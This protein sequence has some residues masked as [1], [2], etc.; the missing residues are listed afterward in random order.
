VLSIAVR[1]RLWLLRSPLAVLA[2]L[3]AAS[4]GGGWAAAGAGASG[5]GQR[6][7]LVEQ[8]TATSKTFRDGRG[9]VTKELY[10]GP[11]HFREGGRWK[12]ID[13][14]LV[15]AAENERRQGYAWRM[16]SHRF[17]VLVKPR[18][19]EGFLRFDADGTPVAFSLAGANAAAGSTRGGEVTFAE[20]LDGV[21]LRY[22]MRPEGVK[23]ELILKHR[24]APST[25][26]FHLAMPRGVQLSAQ[27]VDGGGYAFRRRSGGQALFFLHAPF[28]TDAPD[29]RSRPGARTA[30][31]DRDRRDH[32]ALRVERAPGG[33][34]VE[35]AVDESWLRAEGR[36]FPVTVDPTITLQPTTRDGN[37]DVS[38]GACTVDEWDVIDIG[39]DDYGAWRGAFQFDLGQIPPGA[40]VSGAK[41][42]LFN[43]DMYC[44]YTTTED[45]GAR[46]H[47]L[48]VHRMTKAW[49]NNSTTSQLGWDSIAGA[50]TTVPA[51]VTGD[52]WIEFDV[53][54]MV[55]SWVSGATT[56]HGFLVKR[57]TE[58]LDVGG[59]EV[60]GRTWTW[61]DAT[62]RPRLEVTY[63]SDAVQF[64]APETLHGNGAA[65]RWERFDG[66]TGA[67]F[68][69]YEVHRSATASFTPSESTRLATIRDVGVTAFRDTTAAPSKTFTYRIVANGSPSVAQTVT[70][71]ADGQARKVLQ[72]DPRDGQS[73]LVDDIGGSTECGNYG[74]DEFVNVGNDG[75]RERSLLRFDLAGLPANAD[76][77]TATLSAYMS[78]TP[79]NAITIGAHRVTAAWTEGS[80]SWGE[81][82]YDGASWASRT[83]TD[84]WAAP[85][86]DYVSTAAATKSHAATDG[87]GWDAFDVTSIVRSWASGGA[88][89][90]GILLRA[91]DEAPGTNRATWI[92]Y[93]SDDYTVSP[94]LRPKLAVDYADPGAKVVGPTVAVAAPLDGERVR[95]TVN[96]DAAA[97]DDR[98]VE[99]VEFLVDGVVKATDTAAPYAYAWDT[100]TA[101]NGSHALTVRA[102][103]DAGNVRTS[104]AATVTVG[105]S[106]PPA[107]RVT[108]PSTRY[109]DVV[110]AD[111]P[112][113]YWRLGETSGTTAAD[114]SGNGRNGAYADSYLL[115]Q[116]GLLTGDTDRAVK[117]QNAKWDG[118]MTAAVGAN[119][120]TALTAEAW[121][122]YAPVVTTGGM[123]RVLA[124]YWGSSGG[125]LLAVAKSSAGQQIAQF[126]INKGGAVSNA[127]AVV[128]PGK[129]HLAGTYDG[130][131]MRLYVNGAQVAAT[132]LS[133]ALLNTTASIVAGQVVDTDTT[134]D[135]AAAFG[136]ALSAQQ[137]Q[138]HVDVGSGRAI[139]ITGAHTVHAT[140]T[141]DGTVDKVEFYVDGNRFGEDT[142]APYSATLD[143]LG[144]E[145]VYDGAH[146]LTT[147]AYDNHGQVTTSA[148]MS[149]TVANATGS[150]Y[151]ADVASTAVPQAVTYDPAAATQDKHGLDV[152]VTNRSQQ[153]WS[154][155]DVVVRPR[156]IS[157]DATAQIVPGAEVSL[158]AALAPG[159]AKTVRVLVE[160]P[161]LP[162]G[163]DKAQY[164]L[165]VDLYEKS[166]STSFADKG[167]KPLENPVIVN[168]ALLTALGFEKYYQ[169][170]GEELGAGMQQMLN[171]ANG[172]SLLRWTPFE[173]RGR[174]LM[175]VVDL[176]YN[177]LEK[178]SE[179]PIGN[180]FSLSISGLTRFG[181]PIDV[182]PNKADE[183]AGRSNRYVDITDGDG[184]THRFVGRQAADGSVYWEEPDGVH[185]HLRSL[186]DGDPKGKWAF[187]RPDRVTFFYDVEGFPTRVEDAN[188]NAIVYTHEDTP[189]GEDPGGPKKR[190]TRITDAGGRSFG[191]AY[192]SKDEAKK[193]QVRGNVK[194]ITDHSGSALDFDYYDDGNL[195]RLTQRG[196]TNADGTALADRSFVFTYT[197]SSGDAAAIPAAA[198]RVSPDPKTSN[199]STRLFSVRD[200]RGNETTFTYLGPG[201]GQDRWKLASRRDRRNV[202]TTFSYDTTS[203]V[204][205]LNAPLGRTTKYG[206]DVEGKVL[207]IVDPRNDT[208]RL[209]WTA[210]RH[211]RK[212]VEPTGRFTEFAYD[213]NG[214]LTD[215]WNQKREHTKLEYTYPAAIPG[216]VAGRWKAGRTV[217]HVS[218]LVKKTD[219]NGMATDAPGDHEWEFTHDDRGN[220]LKVVDPLDHFTER[221][222]NADG[223]VQWIKD[224][225][226]NQTTF[227]AYD[228][229]GQPSEV[230]DA[231]N[232]KTRFG[233]D[234]DGLLRWVQDPNHAGDSGAAGTER[235]FRTYFDYD[236]FH[237]MGRQSAPK[238]T[239]GDRGQL[240][241]SGGRF[242]PNDNLVEMIGPHKGADYTGTG[243]K[244]THDY[245][246]VD[247]KTL[248]TGP[249][250][251]VDPAGERTRW[252]YDDAN[253]V[254]RI[255]QP[256]GMMTP[257]VD[258]D[259]AT[260]YEY[261]ALDRVLR[262]IR[263]EYDGATLKSTQRIHRCYDGAGDL[264]WIVSARAGVDAVD[265]T[266][267]TPP[268]FATTYAYD[269]A[270][271]MLSQTDAGHGEA[272]VRHT[273]RRELDHNG[274]VRFEIDQRG[275]RS[276]RR[277]DQR[278]QLVEM[279]QPFDTASGKLLSTKYEYDFA[280]NRTKVTPPRG[281]STS[282]TYDKVNRLRRVDLPKKPD[283]DEQQYV[284]RAYDANGNLTATSLPVTTLDPGAGQ[285]DA[286]PA[287]HKTTV[288]HYDPGWVKTQDAPGRPRTRFDYTPEGWQ[289]S[290]QADIPNSKELTWE[291]YVDGA[292]RSQ[293]DRRGDR[294]TYEYDAHNNVTFVNDAS[295][296]HAEGET[297]VDIRVTRD[298]LDR[299]TVVKHQKKGTDR[300]IATRLTE[301]DLGNNLRERI[302][303]VEE[304]DTG[305]VLK[306]GRR[307]RFDYDDGE[308][309]TVQY[310]YG[311]KDGSEADKASDD[312]RITTKR[313]ETGW[314]QERVVAKWSGSDF[315][316]VKQR[317]T[318]DYSDNGKLE[319]MRTRNGQDEVLESHDVEYFDD[320][321]AYVNGHRVK[322][323]FVLRGPKEDAKC[324][325]LASPCVTKYTYDA[326]DKLVEEL[327]ERNG[328]TKKTT[329]DLDTQG[330]VDVE[331]RADGTTIDSDYTGQRLD[332]QT[333]TNGGAR[334]VKKYRYDRE[335]NLDCTYDG[336]DGSAGPTV[337]D[338]ADSSPSSKLLEKYDYDELNR[339]TR[340]RSWDP[341]T[342]ARDDDTTYVYDAL[343]RVIFQNEQHGASGSDQDRETTFSYL[344]TGDEVTQER[345][346]Y[347]R[348]PKADAPQ[349][350]TYSYDAFGNRVGM[351]DERGNRPAKEYSY[352]VDVHGS[353]SLLVD[354]AGKA[355]AQYGYTPY[356]ERD[357][358]LTKE[359]DP[360]KEADPTQQDKTGNEDDAVNP[361]RYAGKRFDSGSETLDMGAR[362]FGPEIGRFIQQ[363]AYDDALDDLDLSTDPLSAN[364]YA[365]A[366]GNPVSFVEADGHMLRTDGGG[367]ATRTARPR[368]RPTRST[369]RSYSFRT[370]ASS[371]GYDFDRGAVERAILYGGAQSRWK[372]F[373]LPK[374]F[375]GPRDG[376]LRFG[377]FIPTET[378]GFGPIKSRGDDRGFETH[379]SP[380]RT[381][382]TFMLDFR[383]RELRVQV[384]P[385]C[386]PSGRECVD[387]EDI[388]S[389]ESPGDRHNQVQVES[390]GDGGVKISYE[391]TNSYARKQLKGIPG[392]PSIDGDLHI[393]PHPK[394]FTFEETAD[395]Y[396]SREAYFDQGGRTQE[397]YRNEAGDFPGPD[398]FHLFPGP[399]G[400]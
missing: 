378:A 325:E 322:D 380:N 34:D 163:V 213:P 274:A 356:G 252:D 149:V 337:C 385:S 219:P 200:P 260:D 396:P 95:G 246:P 165:Q 70:L 302:D 220:V 327:R 86:G 191:I 228:P 106:A 138:A 352:A 387:A 40:S 12:P 206:Y 66:S 16:K 23:E 129:L 381:R 107:T 124:R 311:R 198:D 315:T 2:L 113:A 170:D 79:Y 135:E 126:S 279:V 6:V 71:P 242:D 289:A 350:K 389:D 193:A 278:G 194:R 17:G 301:Y 179:S 269:E 36:R 160:A 365:L 303:N 101:A 321:G 210:D 15:P 369:Q 339:L 51:G 362:R 348:G 248:E 185:L 227:N 277:Y 123:N 91:T 333:L 76:V 140:A 391:L 53:R 217:G 306:Q 154:A 225:N 125:W 10:S 68:D 324:R 85:G 55:S 153:T 80:G 168:K 366:A 146:T 43:P 33:F 96:V 61:G 309:L 209:E 145:P 203:R 69:R 109:D 64:P 204:T 372:T 4:L 230:T 178:K 133:G 299:E 310:D 335:G 250:R 202:A 397:V 218:Q 296:A 150:K 292:R 383:R 314:E 363:D 42:S 256:K 388:K 400:S 360:D 344:A 268:R 167:N 271:R 253:R 386:D 345:R 259:F 144:A 108:S 97:S 236:S 122:S 398:V 238:W 377:L 304:S 102:T 276:E 239:A 320:Q 162:D 390:E 155:T 118:R 247:R 199:Q 41:L 201:F 226:G 29:G 181:N 65:L 141:D 261:D 215:E 189:P 368:R 171:V 283:G 192:W 128:T 371:G 281:L 249:D 89:N 187:T 270:H 98:R 196:G 257:S 157:P 177:S 92:G 104:P 237:R 319:A 305:T 8:R 121:V 78:E 130:T 341:A 26:R 142:T 394:G 284:H 357:E 280:G 221:F 120:G 265:C 119:A 5:H 87:P 329:Y 35:L 99:N 224:E 326:R 44:V 188:G 159:A 21:D 164:R 349:V 205:T 52:H 38:C 180:N 169:Y 338:T 161:P 254:I 7:E 50:S 298:G 176:T 110:K 291:Y 58:P 81:C 346:T 63:A 100:T 14:N 166:T 54:G 312:R 60:T 56:N 158:G 214:Y 267:A 57:A 361:Y 67:A 262:Q 282:Y 62:Q 77:T 45:C 197:T 117:L 313:F 147:R 316:D 49:T 373:K 240:I 59:P 103:D 232:Q 375:R 84:Q 31:Q 331:T 364:R 308:W 264:K 255:T 72:P 343:D 212:V 251:T 90:H 19:G 13:A 392:V 222:Y 332:E 395:D 46:S 1:L 340:L 88:A 287:E 379:F 143:T 370:D 286:I 330:N 3:L 393:N 351:T 137:L 353:V 175:T 105:N 266:A 234:V 186:A 136:R 32:A 116:T 307:Q 20:A 273:V 354:E 93:H 300:W 336:T 148:G 334:L 151:L 359:L 82:T 25:F 294:T 285:L 358:E 216:D 399:W 190:V 318:W 244:T 382:A 132:A 207:S 374:S 233:Y 74:V 258:R 152:T 18:L 9:N 263:Y 235:E 211:V 295:G 367:G 83:G 245:D 174:G 290:R 172:N 131:T 317:T 156:W 342:H 182:H 288:S 272:N 293:T 134:I 48:N 114:A 323:S 115:G 241:W 139:A 229:S 384:N 208:T 195:L 27:P 39:T 75:W 275:T 127:T 112:V 47:T 183:I 94:T 223:T 355:K 73:T 376:V 28:A 243:A 231:E 347:K 22:A 111:A 30:R 173:A 11:I 328:T 24:D 184:T 297:P 37:V